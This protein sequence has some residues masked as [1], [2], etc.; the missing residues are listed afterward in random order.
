MNG[1][2]VRAVEAT[3][4]SVRLNSATLRASPGFTPAGAASTISSSMRQTI[5]IQVGQL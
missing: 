2:R 5:T 1:F 3:P 4:A